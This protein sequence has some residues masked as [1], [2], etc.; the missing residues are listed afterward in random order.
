MQLNALQVY[1]LWLS[2]Q[3]VL[4]AYVSVRVSVR[5]GPDAFS[6]YAGFARHLLKAQ[7]THESDIFWLH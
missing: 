4:P 6:V 5:L 7:Q 1:C 2:Y 3:P